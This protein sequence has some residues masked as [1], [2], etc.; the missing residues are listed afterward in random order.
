MNGGAANFI[1]PKL[2]C[3][4]PALLYPPS[5]FLLSISIIYTAFFEVCTAF[6]EACTAF[7]F[8]HGH[9]LVKKWKKAVKKGRVS[10]VLIFTRN[11]M[12]SKFAQIMR[13]GVGPKGGRPAVRWQ[14]NP[15]LT[16]S[17]IEK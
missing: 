5:S 15:K 10:A 3:A 9:F 2:K 11:V 14:V 17:A 6:F 12:D 7:F 13:E 1:L 16:V 4:D 8:C